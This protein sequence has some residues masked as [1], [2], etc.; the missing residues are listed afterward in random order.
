MNKG[1]TVGFS[2]RKRDENY[3]NHIKKTSGI[4]DI[5]ILCYENNGEYSL[6]ELYNKIINESKHDIVCLIHDDLILPG[7]NWGKSILKHFEQTNFGVIGVAGTTDLSDTGKWWEDTTKMVGIVKH[8]KDGKTWENK[9]SSNFGKEIIETIC[10]DGVFISLDKTKIQPFNQDYRGFHFYDI[11][12]SFNNH[13]NGVKVGVCFDVRVTHK[14]IGET[15]DQWEENRKQFVNDFKDNL[16]YGIKPEIQYEIKEKQL[17]STPKITI[18]I[19]T[20]GNVNLLLNC[21][22][23]IYD[24][25]GYPGEFIEVVIADTG[26]T[27]EEKEQIKSFI[28]SV[29][30]VFKDNI[31]LVEYDFYNF[32]VINNDVVERYIDRDS[33]LLLFCNNDIKVVNNVINLMMDTYLKNKKT[34]GT[35]GCRLHYGDN[36]IQHS[37]MVMFISPNSRTNGQNNLFNVHL[38]HHGLRSYYNY[39]NYTK[40]GVLGNT[41]AFMMINK[42]LFKSIGGFNTDYRECFE[43]VELNMECI[44]RGKENIFVGEGVCYHYE[45]QTRNKSEDKLKR[46]GED[47]MR[48]LVPFILRNE[49]VHEYF[50]NIK[51]KDFKVLLKQNETMIK[52]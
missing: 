40:K 10:I 37:G 19:P 25:G 30:L 41:A 6:T 12:W 35:I 50:G 4:R 2:T 26:S 11:P 42:D 48:K 8:T 23:S 46:E 1:L 52:I 51:A 3:I 38:S 24:N 29:K 7:T 20:K 15:N 39:H 34:V 5:E 33:E 27:P 45:S 22:S 36:T 49:K 31:K 9:Y 32:A 47:Y 17:K 13:L 44:N 16:P 43:D 18:I 14:S 21:V 28:N